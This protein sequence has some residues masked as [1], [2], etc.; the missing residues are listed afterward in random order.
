MVQKNFVHA[1][2]VVSSAWKNVEILFLYLVCFHK[3]GRQEIFVKVSLEALGILPQSSIG[4]ECTESSSYH[5][6]NHYVV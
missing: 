3:M 4:F 5:H 6:Q 2:S 1:G